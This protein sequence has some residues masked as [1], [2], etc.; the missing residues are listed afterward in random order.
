[1]NPQFYLPS[2]QALGFSFSHIQRITVRVLNLGFKIRKAGQQE[3]LGK[4]L[5][6]YDEHH[7]REALVIIIIIQSSPSS[8]IVH[9]NI[10]DSAHD[11][12]D[13][14]P[15]IQHSM[16]QKVVFNSIWRTDS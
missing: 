7:Y 1:V 9:F 12:I 8:M 13:V 2:S 15:L 6:A 5:R 14:E 3:T 11:E 10:R 16:L 4:E